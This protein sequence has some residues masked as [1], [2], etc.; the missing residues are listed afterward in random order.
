MYNSLKVSLVIPCY[1]EEDGIRAVLEE[2]PDVVDEVVVVD[3]NCTDRTA[4]V[5]LSMGAKVVSETRQGYGAAYKK[6]FSET[7]G[8]IITT[9]DADG[10]YP[11]ESIPYLLKVLEKENLDFITVRRVADRVRTPASWLR[12]F[13]DVVLAIAMYFLFG[14]KIFDSQSGMWV[15][16][17]LILNKINLVSDGMPLS[18]ELKIEAFSHKEIRAKEITQ[19]YHIKRIGQS[20]LRLFR[21]GFGNLFFLFKKRF[22]IN[23]HK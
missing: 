20:K 8:D 9:M 1:N 6:G 4:D 21:D 7:S 11:I 19:I 13:G 5:A 22:I 23:R 18:E 10:M 12:Y 17:K 2:V 3:N 14:V 16:R 15:F